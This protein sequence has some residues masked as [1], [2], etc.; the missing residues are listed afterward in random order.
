MPADPGPADRA[1]Y[2]A[3]ALAVR[4]VESGMKLGLGT[5]S[6][7]AWM[8]RCLARR[9]R[10]EGLRIRG[11]PTSQRTAELA[12]RLGIP[13]LSLDEAGWLDLTID[14]ADEIDPSLDLIKGG[15]AALLRE[16]IVAKASDRMIVIADAAKEVPALGV[17]PLP[18]EVTRFGWR[19]TQV[20]IE[21]ALASMDVLGRDVIPRQREGNLVVTDEGNHILDLHLG[22]IGDPHLLAQALN[23]IPGVV[24][25][26]LF[27]D[28]CNI[29]V[30]GAAD[31]CV[32]IRHT[33]DGDASEE[34]IEIDLADPVFADPDR[35]A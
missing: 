1:K 30:I 25:S 6:T 16:K 32:R 34:R 2:A 24:E 20:L 22:R 26:G 15:G 17:F 18:V 5:G 11:V 21:R 27:M 13:I 4:Y 14:G 10:D 28:I 35:L 31:G 23:Q 33:A 3:A 19:T 29:A 12:V 7:A 9:T 8:L